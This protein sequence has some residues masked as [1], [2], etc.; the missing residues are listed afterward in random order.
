MCQPVASWKPR[1]LTFSPC[2][3]QQ[4]ARPTAETSR[5]TSIAEAGARFIL[6]PSMTLACGMSSAFKNDV[7]E[8]QKV[9]V[10][11]T[12]GHWWGGRW[13]PLGQTRFY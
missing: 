13:A 9:D 5:P 10:I 2:P 4:Y 8:V 6:A 7:V 3:Q 12:S 11:A 1:F